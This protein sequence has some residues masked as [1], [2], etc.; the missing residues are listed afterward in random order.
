MSV[1]GFKGLGVQ[2]VSF[3][4]LGVPNSIIRQGFRG[5]K[6]QFMGLGV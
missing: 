6:C 2:N 5:S 1:Q 3:R 4:G